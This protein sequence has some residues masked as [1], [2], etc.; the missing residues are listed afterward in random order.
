[1]AFGKV[2][3]A[4]GWAGCAPHGC[5]TSRGVLLFVVVFELVDYEFGFEALDCCLDARE[6]CRHFGAENVFALSDFG[7]QRFF[8]F[9]DSAIA[10]EQ[11]RER[12]HDGYR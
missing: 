4:L 3:P 6:A 9:C 11:H 8:C 7:A 12:Q 5:G 1:M 2:G 10:I